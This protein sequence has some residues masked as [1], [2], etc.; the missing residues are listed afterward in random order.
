MAE[1]SSETIADV[2]EQL[3]D[4]RMAHGFVEDFQSLNVDEQHGELKFGEAPGFEET[5]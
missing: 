4:D 5:P 2:D 3:I 1:A